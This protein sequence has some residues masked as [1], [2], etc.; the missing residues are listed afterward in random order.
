MT[1]AAPTP[2]P[3]NSCARSFRLSPVYAAEQRAPAGLCSPKGRPLGAAVLPGRML[4]IEPGLPVHAGLARA[5]SPSWEALPALAHWHP[6][7]LQWVS[8][9]VLSS[10]APTEQWD[11][12]KTGKP[13]SHSPCLSEGYEGPGGQRLLPAG[14]IKIPVKESGD[15]DCPPNNSLLSR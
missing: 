14:S 15:S 11:L 2:A 8:P 10:P 9:S 6:L 12:R 7:R 3:Q 4:D 1:T 13:H 5:A